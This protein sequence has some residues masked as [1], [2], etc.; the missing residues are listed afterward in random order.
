[1]NIQRGYEIMNEFL[2]DS[3]IISSIIAVLGTLLAGYVTSF[4]AVKLKKKNEEL[5]ENQFKLIRTVGEKSEIRK[6]E[7]LK[8]LKDDLP[9]GTDFNDILYT[10]GTGNLNI[11]IV[12]SRSE[13]DEDLESFETLITSYHNQALNQSSVQFW[14]SIIASVVGFILIIY[15]MLTAKTATQLDYVVRAIPGIMIECVAGLF[16]KQATETRKRATDFFDKLRSDK[17]I[18]KGIIIANSIEDNTLKSVTKSQI[19]LMMAGIDCEKI[20]LI[21]LIKTGFQN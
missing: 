21:E 7:L 16:F 1:M 9:Q 3:T 18:A 4:T 6:L 2:F 19:A 20:D 14:F 8:E 15:M 17:Q 13:K 12:S 10:I 11:P 5:Q